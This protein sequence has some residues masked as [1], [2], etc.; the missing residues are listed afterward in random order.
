MRRIII[1]TFLCIVISVFCVGCGKEDS[2]SE[3][4]FM[5]KSD[6][7]REDYDDYRLCLMDYQGNVYYTDNKEN[8]FGSMENI[9]ENYKLGELQKKMI[10]YATRDEA[11]VQENYNRIHDI[12]IQEDY[13]LYHDGVATTA[14]CPEVSWS[15][16]YYDKT[17]EIQIV[18]LYREGE[19]DY[20]PYNDTVVEVVEW[21]NKTMRTK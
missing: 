7:G 13:E 10:L 2:M 17:G 8:S 12:V 21:M 19:V 9:I 1:V 5:Y 11:I 20:E 16:V 18:D 14:I 6:Y 15:F 3:I 4:V